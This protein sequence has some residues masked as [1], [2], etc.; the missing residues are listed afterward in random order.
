MSSE[1]SD[2]VWFSSLPTK[3]ARLTGQQLLRS[4]IALTKEL[5]NSA[6]GPRDAI[7]IGGWVVTF[8]ENDELES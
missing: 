6:N 4:F 8:D 5:Q 3:L 2:K 1:A 7:S